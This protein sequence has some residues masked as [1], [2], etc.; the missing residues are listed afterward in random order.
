M[1]SIQNWNDMNLLVLKAAVI[2]QFVVNTVY[3]EQWIEDIRQIDLLLA[4]NDIKMHS[5][6]EVSL[7][8]VIYSI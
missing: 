3:S 1:R 8:Q 4:T 2:S 6:H 7:D 5:S